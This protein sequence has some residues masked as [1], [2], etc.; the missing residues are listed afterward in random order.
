MKTITLSNVVLIIL[1]NDDRLQSL[2]TCDCK[3]EEGS[4]RVDANVS[5]RRPGE[6][7]GTRTELKNISSLKAVAAAVEFEV[8]RQ[9][10]LLE[11]GQIVENETRSFDADRGRTVAM[12]DKQ[13]HLDYRWGRTFSR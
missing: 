8:V 1:V 5:V 13:V 3:M 4:L 6:P 2:G 9:I 11:G 7:L 10:G 12:R